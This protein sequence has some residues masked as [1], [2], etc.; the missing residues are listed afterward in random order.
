MLEHKKTLASMEY[1]Y[2]VYLFRFIDVDYW[3]FNT[4]IEAEAKIAEIESKDKNDKSVIVRLVSSETLKNIDFQLLVNTPFVDR[5]SFD[6]CFL[7]FLNKELLFQSLLA[8]EDDHEFVKQTKAFLV[9]QFLYGKFEATYEVVSRYKNIVRT[10]LTK[11]RIETEQSD[12]LKSH[13]KIRTLMFTLE[14][15]QSL[16]SLEPDVLC[17]ENSIHYRF[18]NK[19]VTVE[20]NPNVLPG[21]GHTYQ[22]R[23]SMTKTPNSGEVSFTH[24]YFGCESFDE[25][26]AHLK[27]EIAEE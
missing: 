8:I 4:K 23:T 14:E 11:K 22:V 1:K 15:A 27:G 10:K 13:L 20:F 25:L 26:L 16:E 9:H 12:K 3:G 24:H 6:N 18:G 2:Y 5:I 17:E 19:N 7:L 21:R